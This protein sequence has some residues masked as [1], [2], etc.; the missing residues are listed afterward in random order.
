MVPSLHCHTWT[1]GQVEVQLL[2]AKA[3]PRVNKCITLFLALELAKVEHPQWSFA[4]DNFGKISKAQ[5]IKAKGSYKPVGLK[6]K[7]AWFFWLFILLFCWFGLKKPRQVKCKCC[8]VRIIDSAT[9]LGFRRKV[10]AQRPRT[11][12]GWK[13]FVT[14]SRNND[15]IVFSLE[16]VCCLFP[17]H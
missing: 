1:P 15:Y 2:G 17:N 3:L 4:F 9:L 5:T 11:C 8:N 16:W 6:I 10:L 7:H 14:P 13:I 12:R